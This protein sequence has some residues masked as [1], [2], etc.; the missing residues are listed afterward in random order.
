MQWKEATADLRIDILSLGE[1]MSLPQLVKPEMEDLGYP[2]WL[3]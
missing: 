1:P 3:N 2:G